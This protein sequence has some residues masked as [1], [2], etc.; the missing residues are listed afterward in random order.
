MVNT[1]ENITTDSNT[2]VDII[3]DEAKTKTWT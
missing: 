3:I 1:V 2:D